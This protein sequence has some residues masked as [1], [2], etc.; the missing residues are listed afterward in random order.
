VTRC[1]PVAVAFDHAPP[2]EVACE[3]FARDAFEAH[4]PGLEAARVGVHVMS[5]APHKT[6]NKSLK[7]IIQT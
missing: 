7:A 3:V 2:S 4:H 5:A 6:Q 1:Q